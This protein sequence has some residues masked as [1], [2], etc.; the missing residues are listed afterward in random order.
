[1]IG[2]NWDWVVSSLSN[3]ETIN[4]N[5]FAFVVIFLTEL[6]KQIWNK[7]AESTFADS[8]LF[9]FSSIIFKNITVSLEK[10]TL[11]KKML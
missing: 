11:Q 9:Y 2:W 4:S 5:W 8:D 10:A 6:K 1:M 7:I 3:Q